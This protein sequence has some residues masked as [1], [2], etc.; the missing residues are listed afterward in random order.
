MTTNLTEEEREIWKDAYRM[1]ELVHDMQGSEVDW[2]RF[3]REAVPLI[4]KHRGSAYRLAYHLMM[5][6][7]DYMGEEQK[8]RM[9]EERMMPEQV[10]MEGIPWS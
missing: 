2:E 4:E 9:E 1:H 6:L 10:M 3:I 7:I 8:A 5:A